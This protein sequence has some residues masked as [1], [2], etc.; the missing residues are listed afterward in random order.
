MVTME[1]VLPN[2]AGPAPIVV[3]AP[4][5]VVTTGVI[6]TGVPSGG[7][8]IHGA[9]ASLVEAEEDVESVLV[10]EP[11]VYPEVTVAP[12]PV[13]VLDVADT[14]PVDVDDP[15]EAAKEISPIL[16]KTRLRKTDKLVSQKQVPH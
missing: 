14:D 4:L 8:E 11:V 7:I 1:V 3:A 15:V 2:T 6:V 10:A 9:R 5:T 12:D 13:A 16:P